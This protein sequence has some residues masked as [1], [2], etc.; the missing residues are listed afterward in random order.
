ME[1]IKYWIMRLLVFVMFIF[2]GAM[3]CQE[4]E[5]FYGNGAYK[6]AI[7]HLDNSEEKAYLKAAVENDPSVEVY[8]RL[9]FK[10]NKPKDVTQKE[11]IKFVA[12]AQKKGNIDLAKA[13]EDYAYTVYEINYICSTPMYK[14]LKIYHYNTNNEIIDTLNIKKKTIWRK[15][16]PDS[17]LE[18]VTKYGCLT[19]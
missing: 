13:Y 4:W 6:Y 12:S 7:K 16:K 14:L 9:L 19:N 10:Y 15:P 8:K 17:P 11:A 5:P 3:Y 18:I 1:I 2:S